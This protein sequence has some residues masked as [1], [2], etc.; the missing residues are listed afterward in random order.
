MSTTANQLFAALRKRVGLEVVSHTETPN[1]LR[2]LGR[3]P[4]DALGLNGN[5]WKIVKYRLLL[6]MEDRPWK[7]DLSKSYFIRKE[8]Q[9]MVFAWRVLLQGENVAQHYADVINIIETSPSARAE[10]LEIP[11]A[12]GGDRNNTAG[13]RR[14]AGP[15]GTVP[16]GPGAFQTKAMGG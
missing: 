8:T 13:G 3:I 10:V 15:V 16:V 11:L 4:E 7:V 12:A 1:Q 14:G 2:I 6:A 5:N 9:K